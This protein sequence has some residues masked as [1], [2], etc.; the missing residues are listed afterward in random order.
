MEMTLDFDREQLNQLDKA[1]LIDLVL[2]LQHHVM[3][4]QGQLRGLES[5][6]MEQKR[7][8]QE[9]R[10]QLAKDSHNSSKPPGSDGPKKA[11]TQSL[12]GKGER[13]LGG[14]PGHQ[15]NT[16]KMVAEPDQV[17]VHPV[18]VCPHCQTDLEAV[19]AASHSQ[20]QV[21][22]LPPTR[23]EVT[24]H[25]AEIKECPGC[26]Q[27][28]MGGFP[29][30]VTQPVQYGPRILAQ[31]SYLNNYHFIPLERTEEVLTDLYGQSPTASV[32]M[33]ASQQL[34]T[35]TAETLAR[36][37]EE[38]RAVSVAHFDESGLRVAGKSHWL[39]VASTTTLTHFHVHQKR[40]QKGM[41]MGEILPDFQGQAVHDH[42]A[43]YLTFD[44]SQH[45]FCN[46][47]HLRE[48]LFI[49]EQYQQPWADELAQLLRDGYREVQST[50]SPAMSLPAERLE[51]YSTQYDRILQEG[52]AVNPPPPEPLP[53]QRGRP[54]QTPP[55]NLLDR[56]QTHKA[57]VLAFLYDFRVPFDNNLA[58][59]DIRM[60]KVKQK[61]SGGFRTP[62]GADTFA[63]IRSYISTARKQGHNVM[64]AVYG[65]F[66]GSPFIPASP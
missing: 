23:I 41:A 7:L 61:V 65:A 45:C 39:H 14:Q 19:E 21:F 37:R 3:G 57:G 51:Y 36:I 25:R 64:D 42:W 55:K 4:Q 33:A 10:D 13:P 32:I 20:R 22:D 47:H 40:G 9:L 26:H 46:A 66:V 44:Q 52:F 34:A 16:L 38:L 17:V 18:T 29:A 28:V 49:Q 48:L 2:V 30:E 50:P 43:A 60:I 5:Q 35:A 53:K 31:A 58:E 1:S 56:L 62:H 8:L 15:G 63:A 54:K 24:A 6:A 12:R 27:Q 11:K 59:R